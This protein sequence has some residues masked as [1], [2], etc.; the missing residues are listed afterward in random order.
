M[1]N[2]KR[3]QYINSSFRKDL[4]FKDNKLFY[5]NK[6][7][8][9]IEGKIPDFINYKLD[10]LTNKMSDFYNDVK[11]PNYDDLEDYSSLYDKGIKNSFTRR[12]D[13]SIN[14]GVKV[15]E[16]G[17][18][19]GQLS[20]FL[21]RGNR[22][23]YGVDLS[24]ESLILGEKFREKN[25]IENVFFIK[26]DFFDLK[27]KNNN[28]DYVIS[29]GVL[30]HTKNAQQAFKCLVNVL[31]PGGIIIIGLYHKYGR[32]FTILKQNLAKLLGKNI[33][34]LDKK[35]R[36]IKSKRKRDA[37]VT[38]QFF[39]PNETLHTPQEIFEWFK[40][41]KIKFLNLIPHIDNSEESIFYQ[42]EIPNFSKLREFSMI[43]NS[44]QIEEGGFFVMIGQ[45]TI[46]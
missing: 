30:H 21:A 42:N 8:N 12:I 25:Q 38:D 43:L 6:E 16:V 44:R 36:N 22:K 17:C 46:N 15:I 27:F 3:Y 2:L 20:L 26:I 33:Y 13:Q 28:F 10:K 39:N 7:I 23:I 4:H 14:Y 9:I 1:E 31:K 37:W 32:F 19:T 41:N 24:Q 35:S 18:G 11:F 29:N 34:M 40:E 45:K 5:S